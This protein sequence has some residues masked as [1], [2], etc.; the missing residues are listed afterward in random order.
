MAASGANYGISA[1]GRGGRRF[2]ER[3][4]LRYNPL[5]L[6]PLPPPRFLIIPVRRRKSACH[7]CVHMYRG[8]YMY[9]GT[10]GTAAFP[11]NGTRYP[12]NRPSR[13]FPPCDRRYSAEVKVKFVSH[14]SAISDD[15]PAITIS[16]GISRFAA[17][18]KGGSNLASLRVSISRPF[19]GGLRRVVYVIYQGRG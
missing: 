4:R 10:W 8:L 5:P 11:V 1:V 12:G 19:R 17:V 15:L 6:S 9:V 18:A 2:F 14:R 13:E 3:T 16:H 7:T